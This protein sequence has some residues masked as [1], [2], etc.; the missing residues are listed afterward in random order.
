[1][2]IN[3][4]LVNIT[5]TQDA[6]QMNATAERRKARFRKAL[7]VAKTSQAAFARTHGISPAH[8]SFV[9]SGQRDSLTLTRKIDAFVKDQL[10]ART[11]AL[12]G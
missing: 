5:R 11:T 2:Y 4:P 6:L 12:A 3:L 7:A 9:L 1:M 10:G 8:L